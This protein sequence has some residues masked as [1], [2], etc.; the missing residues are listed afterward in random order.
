M[1]H[2]MSVSGRPTSPSC[3][4]SQLS[5]CEVSEASGLCA[6]SCRLPKEG[7]VAMAGGIRLRERCEWRCEDWRGDRVAKTGVSVGA[8]FRE[9]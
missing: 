5:I 1:L 6:T 8:I 2:S 7:D 4:F 9:G 3:T